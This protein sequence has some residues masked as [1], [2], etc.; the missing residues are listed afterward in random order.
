MRARELA[1]TEVARIKITDY[2]YTGPI[3]QSK[4]AAIVMLADASEAAVRSLRQ[5]NMESIREMIN[6]IFQK[7]FIDGQLNQSGLNLTDL[8]KLAAE[9]VRVLVGLHHH[10][11]QYPSQEDAAV[12][13]MLNKMSRKKHLDISGG[14]LDIDQI[15]PF[16]AASQDFANVET[17]SKFNDDISKHIGH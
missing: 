12:G 7:C 5:P 9:F 17:D 14:R 13:D 4:E 6:K 11:I 3:P 8:Q 15:L 16:T 2:R 10:R 1:G